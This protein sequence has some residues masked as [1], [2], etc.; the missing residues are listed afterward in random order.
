MGETR[1]AKRAARR[2]K[3]SEGVTESVKIART[4]RAW[5]TV[6]L[7]KEG[8]IMVTGDGHDNLATLCNFLRQSGRV[9]HVQSIATEL[10]NG[11]EQYE[12]EKA[13]ALARAAMVEIERHDLHA[14]YGPVSERLT[15]DLPTPQDAAETATNEH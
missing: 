8:E 5:A 3:D 7:T 1:R 15:S 14:F 12:P 2:P 11:E 10:V 4:A 6:G 9:V 13:L